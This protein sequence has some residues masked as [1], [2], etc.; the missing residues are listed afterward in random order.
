[1]RKMLWGAQSAGLTILA[2]MSTLDRQRLAPLRPVALLLFALA[3]LFGFLAAA[4]FL[5]P[6]IYPLF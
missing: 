1:M 6:F 2:L 3:L 5:S 4:P